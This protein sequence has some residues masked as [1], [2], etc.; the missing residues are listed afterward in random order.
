MDD[1][2]IGIKVA[3]VGICGSLTAFWGWFGWLI[4]GW[5]FC[6]AMDY[7]TGSAAACKAGEWESKVARDGLWHK[8]GEIVVVIVAGIADL[9]LGLALDH[10]PVLALPLDFRGLVCPLVLVWYILTELGSIAE[11]S[12]KMGS[13][14]P[15]WLVQLLKAG[16][17][18]AEDAG[19]KIAQEDGEDK[20][21]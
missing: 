20:T 13:D 1:V 10:L 4:C 3:V 6:M 19:D 11:N 18:A 17:K 15:P 14:V 8:A 7:I 21:E 9:L 12:V 16:Q 2:L 5:I